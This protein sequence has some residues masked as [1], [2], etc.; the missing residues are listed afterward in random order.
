VPGDP[1]RQGQL[2]DEELAAPF[3]VGRGGGNGRM[4]PCRQDRLHGNSRPEGTRQ[5]VNRLVTGIAT[6]GF[7]PGNRQRSCITAP[8]PLS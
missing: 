1:A 3:Y 6:Y 8:P 4:Q 7:V 5:L 2:T